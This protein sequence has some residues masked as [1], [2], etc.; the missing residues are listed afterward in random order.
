MDPNTIIVSY[1]GLEEPVTTEHKHKI[2]DSR[3]SKVVLKGMN[4]G[5]EAADRQKQRRLTL[6]AL[7]FATLGAAAPAVPEYFQLEKRCQGNGDYCDNA[8]IRLPVRRRRDPSLCCRQGRRMLLSICLSKGCCG[9]QYTAMERR[10]NGIVMTGNLDDSHRRA[11]FPNIFMM[12][13]QV[14]C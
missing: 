9:K 7:I 5:G 12:L 13:F 10:C 1:W 2:D 3:D 8:A 11:C 4:G 6:V 14:S